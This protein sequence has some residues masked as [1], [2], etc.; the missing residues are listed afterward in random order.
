MQLE[1]CRSSCRDAYS[2]LCCFFWL[3]ALYAR[4]G[5]FWHKLGA[6]IVP[7]YHFL[8]EGSPAK[9]D[10]MKKSCPYSN[11]ST[12]GPSKGILNQPCD[13][14]QSANQPRDEIQSAVQVC[15][16]CPGCS[17]FVPSTCQ[18]NACH[19]CATGFPACPP[20]IFINHE[21]LV[22]TSFC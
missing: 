1:T 6:P 14:R 17:S 2:F 8:G 4:N 11:L 10:H 15:S 5:T 9:P 7:F 20:N 21:E 19:Q 22:S 16:G 18:S 3:A 12:G 13:V